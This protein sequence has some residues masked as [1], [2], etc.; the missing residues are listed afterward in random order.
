MP[1]A[2]GTLTK[3]QKNTRAINAER[4]K[5]LR[6]KWLLNTIVIDAGHGGKDPGAVAKNGLLE[7]LIFWKN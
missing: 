5:D 4:I 2:S 7:K 1:C 6:N 3:P